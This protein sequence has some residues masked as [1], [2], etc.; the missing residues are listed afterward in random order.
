M[1]LLL[2]SQDKQ[3]AATHQQV[4]MPLVLSSLQL[5]GR[6]GNPLEGQWQEDSRKNLLHNHQQHR[7]NPSN[8]L[9]FRLELSPSFQMEHLLSLVWHSLVAALL[10][11][12]SN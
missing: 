3:V 4:E 2:S 9:R 5:L 1:L 7:K 10:R 12:V 6:A 11:L 8:K